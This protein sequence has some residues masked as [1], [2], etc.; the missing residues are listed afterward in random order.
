VNLGAIKILL[1]DIQL[2]S[3]DDDELYELCGFSTIE[4]SVE[5]LYQK[6]KDD[7]EEMKS[8]LTL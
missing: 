1:W 8:K 6:V 2:V 3:E 7:M 5:A 4:D